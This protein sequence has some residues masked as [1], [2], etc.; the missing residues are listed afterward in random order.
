MGKP[1]K[2]VRAETEDFVA[3]QPGL[4]DYPVKKGEKG[5]LLA[6]RCRKCGATFF[7]R[8]TVCRHCL[9]E[10]NME[11]IRLSPRG[12]IYACTVVHVDSPSGVKAP[13]AFGY[14]DIPADNIR[15]FA[16]FSSAD[17]ELIEPGQEV[18]LVLEPIATNDEHKQVIGYKYRPLARRASK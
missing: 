9:N 1:Q 18:E 17:R 10:E 15:V 12:V 11:G 14:V 4:F 6:S 5:R 2:K 7:P 13:Y 16:L 8:R 3:V